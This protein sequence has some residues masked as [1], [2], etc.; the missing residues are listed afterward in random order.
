MSE[1]DWLLEERRELAAERDELRAEN[2]AF[3]A[4]FDADGRS[5]KKH[6]AEMSRVLDENERLIKM[7]RRVENELTEGGD[8]DRLRDEVRAALSEGATTTGGDDHG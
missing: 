1:Y 7:L 6:V 4:Q 3:R 5:W 2:E 8:V